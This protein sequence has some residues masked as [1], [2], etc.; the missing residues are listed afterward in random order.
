LLRTG[1]PLLNIST[2]LSQGSFEELAIAIGRTANLIGGIGE[3]E[4]VGTILMS[5]GLLIRSMASLLSVPLGFN[6]KKYL[7]P[8]G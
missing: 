2:L 3:P 1:S 8:G 5:S 6:P 7:D 4:R